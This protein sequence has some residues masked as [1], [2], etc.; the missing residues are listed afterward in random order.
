[1]TVFTADQQMYRVA[2]NV[3]WV[4]PELSDDFFVLRLGGM[5]TLMSFVGSVGAL[6]GN[7]GL[8]E[9]LK[10]AFGGVIQMLTGKNFP[11][12]TRALRMVAEELLQPTISRAESQE[13][14]MSI[15]E[16]EATKNRTG[17]VWVE[18]LIIPV[19]I[20][21][22]YI[23]AERDAELSLHLWAM[24]QMIPYFFATGH[25]NYARYGLYYLRSMERLP[26]NV[27]KLFLNGE[28]VMRHNP[29]VWNGIWSDMFIETTFM[30][31]GKGTGGL[32]GVTLERS[33]VKDGH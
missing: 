27:V 19:L 1:M 9:V 28:H 32:V 16:K 31:Y 12:N 26:E 14:L 8:E 11:Q 30:R 6:I 17:K 33:T 25:V 24:Q 21:M 23:R 18:N 4:Y 29:G 20:M 3:V 5:H 10:A 15:L 22:I 7:S 2:V 13:G